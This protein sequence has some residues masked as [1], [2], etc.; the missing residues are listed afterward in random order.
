M[1]DPMIDMIEPT[2]RRALRWLAVCGLAALTAAAGGRAQTDGGAAAVEALDRYLAAWNARDADAFAATFHYPHTR[3]SPA[4]SDAG[5]WRSAERYAAGVDFAPLAAAGWVRS[6]WE[7]RTVVHAGADKVH[8]AGRARRVDADGRTLATLQT[9]YV[10]ARQEGRWAVQA[11]F[12]A[13]PPA[14]GPVAAASRRG[15]VAVVEAYLDAVNRR[16]PQGFADTLHYPHYRVARGAIQVWEQAREV[17]S[18]TTFERLAGTGWVRS[19]WD[20]VQ[21]LQ[22]SRDG[23]N[24]GLELS[25]YDAGGKRIARF[26]TLYLVTRQDGRWGIK[27]RS[28]FAPR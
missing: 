25:R 16:D 11:R 15:A 12:S 19:A 1:K 5:L 28:S 21:P 24:V 13:G 6:H 17:A 7:A 8:L 18:A 23:V 2:A 26:H 10:L 27:A 4:V 14:D 22:V 20:S 3:L 9:L